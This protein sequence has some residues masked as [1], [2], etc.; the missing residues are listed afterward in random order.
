MSRTTAA[1]HLAHFLRT[2]ATPLG[3]DKVYMLLEYSIEASSIALLSSKFSG[4]AGRRR[5]LGEQLQKLGLAIST[6]RV[7]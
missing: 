1:K 2:T 3:A 7:L 6:A 5:Q 4:K